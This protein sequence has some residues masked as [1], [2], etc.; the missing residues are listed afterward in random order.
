MNDTRWFHDLTTD[1]SRQERAT[2][3]QRV[4]AWLG[5]LCLIVLIGLATDA[6]AGP[7]AQ[8]V[9]NDGAKIVLTDE[10][11]ALKEVTNLKYRATWTEKGK[12]FQGCYAVHPFGV[13]VAYFTDG[14]VALM[15]I[16]AFTKVTGA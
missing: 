8:T 1:E 5:V 4:I 10:P 9:T 11:C 7:M 6:Y 3:A 14:A 13:V 16:D 15:P 12:V 2:L